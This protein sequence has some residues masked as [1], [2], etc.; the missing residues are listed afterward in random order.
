MTGIAGMAQAGG[1][2]RLKDSRQASLTAVNALADACSA[3]S[4]PCVLHQ[5]TT[6]CLNLAGRNPQMAQTCWQWLGFLGRGQRC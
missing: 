4:S 2:Q 3:Y 5:R 6:R 1:Q